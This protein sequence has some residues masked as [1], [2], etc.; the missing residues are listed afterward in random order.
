MHKATKYIRK[1]I[2][3]KPGSTN[4]SDDS[5]V[6]PLSDGKMK[7]VQEKRSKIWKGTQSNMLQLQYTRGNNEQW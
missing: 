6:G 7:E 4:S 5:D 3:D 2:V 1:Q